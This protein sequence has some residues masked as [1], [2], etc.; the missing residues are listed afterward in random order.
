MIDTLCLDGSHILWQK[1]SYKILIT[2]LYWKI[3]FS[4]ESFSK[5]MKQQD[6]IKPQGPSFTSHIN[7][8]SLV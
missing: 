2:R 5:N 8:A 4:S 6:I 1:S 3:M 7:T